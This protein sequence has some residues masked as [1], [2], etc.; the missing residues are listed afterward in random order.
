[1]IYQFS[2]RSYKILRK[3]GMNTA[4]IM[5]YQAAMSAEFN[6]YEEDIR[7]KAYL[8]FQIIACNVL[9]EDE[10]F[11]SDSEKIKGFFDEC[12]NLLDAV[13][14]GSTRWSECCDWFKELTGNEVKLDLLP[15]VGITA[16]QCILKG[17]E[18]GNN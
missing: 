14:T 6:R 15:N 18:N 8:L 17:D 12:E 13:V 11:G 10:F 9:S 1:M 3:S 16:D 4:Q 2:D 7:N 5:A